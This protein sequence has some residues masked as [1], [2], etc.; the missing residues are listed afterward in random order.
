MTSVQQTVLGHYHM[1]AHDSGSNLGTSYA[2]VLMLH[3]E[4]SRVVQ[5]CL[6]QYGV[7]T[8]GAEGESFARMD[9]ALVCSDPLRCL[10]DL[11]LSP[12]LSLSL[13]LSLF[14]SRFLSVP[15]VLFLVV[16]IA[17]S[18]PWWHHLGFNSAQSFG[19][20]GP[21]GVQMLMSD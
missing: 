21:Q 16:I 11:F 9:N 15:L 3:F 4:C 19:V 17:P 2:T 14:L 13:S 18:R 1:D 8:S 20:S 12:S 7:V 5:H 6:G 10:A